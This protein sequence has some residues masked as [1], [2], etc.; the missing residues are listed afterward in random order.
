MLAALM[1]GTIA[2]YMFGG[3]VWLFGGTLDQSLIALSGSGIATTVLLAM[4]NNVERSRTFQQ[5]NPLDLHGD[6]E[7]ARLM[8]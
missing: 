4:R 5:E 6:G 7:P 1:L 2:G 8:T 3:G